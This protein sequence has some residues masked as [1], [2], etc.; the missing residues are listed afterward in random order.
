VSYP[1]ETYTPPERR[2]FGYPVRVPKSRGR[3]PWAIASFIAIPLFFSSLMASTLAQEKPHVIQW[4]GCKNGLC[5]TWHEPT[6]A[7]EAR[8]W[9]WA[10]VPA[11]VL[12][13]IGFL[14]MRVRFGWYIACAAGLI[15]AIAVVHRLN[16]W[17][18][19]HIARFPWGVDLIPATNPSSN[20]YDPGEWE[21]IARETSLSLSHWTI[22]VAV[23]AIVGMAAV[24]VRRRYWSRGP[25]EAALTGLDIEPAPMEAGTSVHAPDA[26]GASVPVE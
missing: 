11:L 3:G 25:L 2:R 26:T 16:R 19:H 21:K 17:T 14:C 23:V 10:L 4:K 1:A 13:L 15:E 7:T 18:V 8:I 5:T 22:G 6:S 12:S 20:Q 24:E 9:L